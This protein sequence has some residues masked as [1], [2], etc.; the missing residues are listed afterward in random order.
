ME[1][2]YL[3]NSGLQV[4][5]LSLGTMTFGNES[6]YSESQAIYEHAR[7]LGINHFDCANFYAGGQAE[8]ILGRLCKGHRQDITIATKAYFPM[9]PGPNQKGLSRLHLVQ[10]LE[11]SLKRLDTDYVDLFYLHRFDNNIPLIETLRTIRDLVSQGKIIYWG[12]SNFTAWQTMQ[13]IGICDQHDWPRPIVIQPMYN[14]LKR[15]AEVE[16]LPM[17]EAT[18]L[19]VIPYSPLAGG[20]LSG[21]YLDHTPQVSRLAV[22]K[23][24]QVRYGEAHVPAIVKSLADYCLTNNRDLIQTALAWVAS[25][26]Q[27][28]S[29]LLGARTLDQFKIS[30]QALSNPLDAAIRQEVTELSYKLPSPLDRNDE[31]N[32]LIDQQALAAANQKF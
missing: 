24:Y 14:L 23:A 19:G 32:N 11:A 12:I 29:L 6:D 16:I 22:N 25:H 10:A 30:A 4:S 18:G 5:R 15:Q 3:G 21:K 27:I 1:Y 28:S 2:Q 20:V 8:T 26:N 7:T 17:A 9:G 31:A 13:A